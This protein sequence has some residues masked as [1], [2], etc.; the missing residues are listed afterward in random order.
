MENL[1]P[2]LQY[3]DDT[4]ALAKYIGKVLNVSPLK[5]DYIINQNS[6][7]IGE[8][9]DAVQAGVSKA[10]TDGAAAG[11]GAG[12]KEF[13]LSRFLVDTAYSEQ[14]TSAYYD[15]REL[16]STFLND[17]D[18]TMARDGLPY[19]PQLKG[20][21]PQQTQAAYTQAKALDKQLNDLTKQL[22][23]LSQMATRAANDGDEEKAREY[24]FKRQELAA[25]GSLHIAEFY[26]RWKQVK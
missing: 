4:S 18:E 22:S 19:S 7:V 2:A 3:T 15:Q 13:F 20:L 17:V 11:V 24:R 5:V 10:Q 16:L 21:N 6:G 12:F 23:A 8:V 25:E 14:V 1:S 9:K 26:D